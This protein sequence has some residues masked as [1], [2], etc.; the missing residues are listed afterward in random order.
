M[1]GFL[2]KVVWVITIL[3]ILANMA[4][5]LVWK[6]GAAPDR[7]DSIKKVAKTQ[8]EIADILDKIPKKIYRGSSDRDAKKNKWGGI[9][10]TKSGTFK[11]DGKII[12]FETPIEVEKQLVDKYK[13]NFADLYDEI[14][15]SDANFTRDG[16]GS[17]L[18]VTKVQRN[19]IV[20]GIGIKVGDKVRSVNDNEISSPKVAK[21]LYDKLKNETTFLVEIERGGK[22]IYILYEIK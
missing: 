17:Y 14:S 9:V 15:K 20:D 13:D 1:I 4:L 12:K 8:S 16:N 21:E 3:V 18:D 5:V 6:R 22:T 10:R 2:E 7:P 11:K 19:S